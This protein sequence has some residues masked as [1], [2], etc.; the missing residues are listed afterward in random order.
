MM[1]HNITPISYMAGN[2]GKDPE[3]VGDKT[4]LQTLIIFPTI[5]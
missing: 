4:E 5:H 3:P 2:R 1:K